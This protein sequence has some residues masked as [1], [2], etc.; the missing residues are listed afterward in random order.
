MFF[1]FIQLKFRYSFVYLLFL[2]KKKIIQKQIRE[3]INS[4]LIFCKNNHYLYIRNL[5]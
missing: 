4:K 2:S 5:L 3:I 1:N